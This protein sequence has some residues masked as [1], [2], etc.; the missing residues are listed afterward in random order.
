MALR[1]RWNRGSSYCLTPAMLCMFVVFMKPSRINKYNPSP[2][3]EAANEPVP[4]F[5]SS[6]RVPG[7]IGSSKSANLS[8]YYI[9]LSSRP[10]RRKAIQRQIS[11]LGIP[12]ARVEAVDVRRN[13]TVIQSCWDPSHVPLCVGKVGCKMSHVKALSLGEAQGAEVVAIFEDDFEWLPDVDPAEVI[14]I[15]SI[16]KGKFPE[17]D[18]IGLSLNLLKMNDT[19]P[20][21]LVRTGPRRYSKVVRVL[22]A[23]TT[24]GYLVKSRYLPKLKANFEGCQVNER[25]DSAIDQCWKTLQ[26]IDE[27]YAFSPQLGVQTPGFSDIENEN[28]SYDVF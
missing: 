18:V 11:R 19:S 28:V 2:Q 16:F 6:E 4:F 20:Q 8:A 3:P 15:I 23:Q 21:V 5:S 17:W 25:Y 9:N 10:D 12:Y 13:Q 14:N 7:A 27:W 26:K 22:N 24:H 1:C